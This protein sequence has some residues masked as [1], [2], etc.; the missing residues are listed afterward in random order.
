M[1]RGIF[2][3]VLMFS[4]VAI[5]AQEMEQKLNQKT[6]LIEVVYYHEN[7]IISQEG[8]FNLDNKLHGI[9]TSY[10]EEGNKIAQGSYVNGLKNGTWYFW[11]EESVREVEYNNNVI[12]GVTKSENRLTKQH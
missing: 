6:N 12:A 1:Y 2:L 9:W 11:T 3:A 4:S 5:Y 8:T 10:D 7:G